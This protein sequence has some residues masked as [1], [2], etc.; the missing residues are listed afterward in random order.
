MNQGYDQIAGHIDAGN[1]K[2]EGT[3]GGSKYIIYSIDITNL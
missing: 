1:Y 3:L 2:Y